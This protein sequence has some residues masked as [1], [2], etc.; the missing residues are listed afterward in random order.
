VSR[1]VWKDVVGYEGMYQVSNMGRIKSF[2]RDKNGRLLK[3]CL[4]KYGYLKVIL[5]RD[6]K[7]KTVKV[8]RL[9]LETFIGDAPSPEHEGNHKNGNRADNRIENLEWTTPSENCKH[10]F[11]VLGRETIRG[12]AHVNAVLMRQEVRRI[13]KLAAAGKHSQR[14]LGKMFGVSQ[15]TI[16]YIVRRETWKH[17]P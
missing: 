16:S 7:R 6:S 14:E 8:H 9:V 17:V 11:R 13:R 3:P 1:E 10:A 2:C 4:D 5:S 15:R 12:E